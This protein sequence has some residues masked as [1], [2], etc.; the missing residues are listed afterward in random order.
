MQVIDLNQNGLDSESIRTVARVT[1]FGSRNNEL[2]DLNR[3]K[4][5]NQ[6]FGRV[7][8]SDVHPPGAGVCAHVRARAHMRTRV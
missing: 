1:G 4:H 8:V 6:G 5:L 3:L 7:C 2:R